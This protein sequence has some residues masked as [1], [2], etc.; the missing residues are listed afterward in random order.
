MH[1]SDIIVRNLK[2]ISSEYTDICLHL[3]SNAVNFMFTST[4]TQLHNL[5]NKRAAQAP[6]NTLIS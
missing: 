4:E 6:G 3:R 5:S 2:E 1:A